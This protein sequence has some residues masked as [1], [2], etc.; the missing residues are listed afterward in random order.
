MLVFILHVFLFFIFILSKI[1]GG[2]DGWFF[3]GINFWGVPS[4]T[5]TGTEKM[6]QPEFVTLMFPF[7]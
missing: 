6:P 2:V 7:V 3:P 5:H 4:R 1:K